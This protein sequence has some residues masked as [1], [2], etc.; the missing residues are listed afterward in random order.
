MQITLI[1]TF[2]VSEESKPAL[3]EASRTIQGILK[4]LPGFV[5]GFVYEKRSGGGPYNIVTTAV[6][7]AKRRTPRRRQNGS[8]VPGDWPQSA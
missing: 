4:T 7:K 8:Q 1:D 6:W 2:I 3:L 5:E